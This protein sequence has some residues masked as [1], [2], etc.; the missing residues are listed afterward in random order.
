MVC[1]WFSG[2]VACGWTGCTGG[3]VCS[4]GLVS[5]SFMAFLKPLIDSP[6]SLPKF[7]SFLVPNTRTTTTSRT[8][9]CFQSKIPIS[10]S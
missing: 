9:Q 6:R 3:G 5:S 10:Y 4:A 8:I 1:G 2:D 7:F